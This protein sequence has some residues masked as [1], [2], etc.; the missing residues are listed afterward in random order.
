MVN[1]N[2]AEVHTIIYPQ[3]SPLLRARTV[4]PVTSPINETEM[5]PDIRLSS[6]LLHTELDHVQTDGLAHQ[7]DEEKTGEDFDYPCE[8]FLPSLPP[9]S[10]PPQVFSSSPFPSSQSSAGD[11]EPSKAV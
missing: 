5:N 10:S 6:I 3:E 7:T 11:V 4:S 2:D 8:D 9:S 1:I